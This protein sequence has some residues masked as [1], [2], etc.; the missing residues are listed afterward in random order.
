MMKAGRKQVVLGLVIGLII[1]IVGVSHCWYVTFF[2]KGDGG[3]GALGFL[4]IFGL[5]T[6]LLEFPLEIFDIVKGFITGL[7]SL[8]ILFM[9][10]WSFIGFLIGKV[11]AAIIKTKS[12][13]LPIS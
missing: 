11:I 13:S 8:S 2:N 4:F 1:G 10:N 6:T 12:G 3:E 9:A 5:P 7:I